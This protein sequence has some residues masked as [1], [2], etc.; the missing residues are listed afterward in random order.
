MHRLIKCSACQSL[1]PPDQ[2]A[3]PHCHTAPTPPGGFGATGKAIVGALAA[4]AAGGVVMT[5]L[6]A[7][8]G[9]PTINRDG[10]PNLKAAADLKGPDAAPDA[11][12]D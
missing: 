10:F 3:C 11:G 1:L 5:T 2:G 6:A 7:C 12:R 9:S 4:L 8:Y